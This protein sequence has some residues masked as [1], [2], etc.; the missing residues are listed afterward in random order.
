MPLWD[1]FVR[2]LF[3]S[4]RPS[5]FSRL[6]AC[7]VSFQAFW[8]NSV[9]ASMWEITSSN[10]A[11]GTKIAA[12]WSYCY[13]V[14]VCSTHHMTDH[15]IQEMMCWGKEYDFIQK[16]SWLRRWQTHVLI[17]KAP[18]AGKD[19]RQE[20][21]GTKEDEMIGWHHQFDGHEFEL[22]LGD[23]EGKGSLACCSL[24]GRKESGKPGVLQSVGSQR[25]RHDWT[26]E[27]NVSE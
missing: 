20:E 15:W 25:V 18:D 11:K 24:W 7:L 19:W 2:Q 13:W 27:L 12:K 1:D 22:A 3:S 16:S 6:I 26:T 17:G 5:E 8:V 9:K 21:K 14:Q 4:Q 10:P 23:G